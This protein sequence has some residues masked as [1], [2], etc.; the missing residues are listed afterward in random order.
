MRLRTCVTLIIVV[1]YVVPFLACG[2]TYGNKIIR[3]ESNIS[4]RRKRGW[5][6]ETAD[7]LKD[8][9]KGLSKGASKIS[10]WRRVFRAKRTL[11]SGAKFLGKYGN[12]ERYG[13]AG[14]LDQA[15]RDFELVDPDGVSTQ[16]HDGKAETLLGMI[17]NN[18][19]VMISG[20]DI[21]PA[22]S[23]WRVNMKSPD[24]SSIGTQI[25]VYYN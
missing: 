17:G 15:R 18:I 21:M 22:I 16:F 10:G 8:V 3:T 19:V 2:D 4:I 14:G 9:G 7:V 6:K 23:M 5:I 25:S 12:T 24:R 1:F 11:K 20:D 13:K